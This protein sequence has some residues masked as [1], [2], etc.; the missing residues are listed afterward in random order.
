MKLTA[1]ETAKLFGAV[2]AEPG[3]YLKLDQTRELLSLMNMTEMA[4]TV[5]V[6]DRT[7]GEYV[8]QGKLPAPQVELGAY[9]YY[10][11]HEAD[12]IRATATKRK[13]H[14]RPGRIALSPDQVQAVRREREAGSSLVELAFRHKVSY[15]TIHNVVNQ[16]GVYAAKL[17]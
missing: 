16:R 3:R 2:M 13:R 12:G 4:R 11:A 10:R 8:R 9:R 17:A 15:A 5:G 1:D 14:A 6:N 7:F